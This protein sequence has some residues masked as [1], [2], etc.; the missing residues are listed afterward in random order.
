MPVISSVNPLVNVARFADERF[1]RFYGITAGSKHVAGN[2]GVDS[3]M[4]QL[5]LNV[6][7]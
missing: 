7:H 2:N 4:E 5:F 6:C 3:A 1:V